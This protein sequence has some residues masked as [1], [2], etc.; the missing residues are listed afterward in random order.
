M[1]D[2]QSEE[3]I[4]RLVDEFYTRVRK[5]D[6]IGPIFNDVIGDNWSHHL[7]IMYRFWSSI[8]LGANT[9][10]GNPLA[11]HYKLELSVDH[12]NRWLS[13]FG[14]TVDDMFEGEVAKEAKK[15]ARSIASIM[16]AKLS[17]LKKKDDN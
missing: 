9:Y 15:R 11:V 4:K 2:I 17:M 16:H 10:H 12:F 14:Q 5:D 8:L 1:Q 7:P 13:F 3:D 6:L